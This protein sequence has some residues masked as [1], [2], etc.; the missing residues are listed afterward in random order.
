LLRCSIKAKGV[1]G[2]SQAYI[3][4]LKTRY[5]MCKSLCI[6]VIAIDGSYLGGGGAWGIQPAKCRWGR[7]VNYFCL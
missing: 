2:I 3:A 1:G 4:I 5:L 6:G 7:L